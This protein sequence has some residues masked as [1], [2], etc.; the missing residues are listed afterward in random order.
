MLIEPSTE[1]KNEYIEMIEEWRDTGEH[2]VPFVLRYDHTD[3]ESFL[4]QIDNL[5]KGVDLKVDTVSSSTYWFISQERKVI[6][7]VNM[8]HSLNDRLLQ[9]GG[10]IGFG[11]R[12]SMRLK[13]YATELLRQSLIKARE[14]NHSRVLI[15]CDKDNHGSAKTIV[16]NGGILD[17]VDVVTGTEIQ[18]YWIEI[19]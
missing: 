1:Y 8:R 11:V 10:H 15:T 13:G 12:P 18:R 5:K 7:A 14:M 17:S 3:F 19:K 4:E 16:N 9:M 6:G 2:L